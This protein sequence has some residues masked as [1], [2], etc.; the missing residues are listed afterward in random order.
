[1]QLKEKIGM[2]KNK[3]KLKD[4]FSDIMDEVS[5]NVVDE[6]I[7]NKWAGSSSTSN[8]IENLESEINEESNDSEDSDYENIEDKIE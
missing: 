3:S 4:Y 1:M 5:S 7:R 2:K 8:A 6:R